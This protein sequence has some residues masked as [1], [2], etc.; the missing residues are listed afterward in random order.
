MF[1]VKI[2]DLDHLRER[3]E[4]YWEEFPQQEIDDAVD[5]F[6]PRLKKMIEV[7]GKKFEHL[8]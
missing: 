3:L 2:C 5:K 7:E 8:L 6:H 1:R 4:T